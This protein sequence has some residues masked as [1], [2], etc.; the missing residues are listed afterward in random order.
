ME[1]HERH[2]TVSTKCE[3]NVSL[4]RPIISANTNRIK[5]TDYLSWDKF[6]PDAEKREQVG[7][8]KTIINPS[9]KASLDIP[10]NLSNEER[11][12]QAEVEKIKGNDCMRAHEYDQAVINY[13]KAYILLLLYPV[14]SNWGRLQ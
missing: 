3:A 1:Q 11:K 5:S 12:R 2:E 9:K 10:Q 8:N 14:T 13:N 6:D 4:Q 7:V